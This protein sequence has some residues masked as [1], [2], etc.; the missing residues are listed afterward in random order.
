MTAE[1]VRC[2][3]SCFPVI[4][5]T[6]ASADHP[7]CS[8]AFCSPR[9][10][11]R[12]FALP[13]FSLPRRYR[14]TA[15]PALGRYHEFVGDQFLRRFLSLR[16][17]PDLFL[18]RADFAIRPDRYGCWSRTRL[19]RSGRN[20][21][22]KPAGGILLH[23]EP[24]ARPSSDAGNRSSSCLRLVA[25]HALRRSRRPALVFVG[26][27]DPT[28]CR[29]RCWLDWLLFGLRNRRTYSNHAP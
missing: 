7:F 4:V 27:R 8:G 3:W 21:V 1:V 9:F 5:L 25:R 19:A 17:L 11:R 2:P 23:S 24:L 22:G 12:G 16:H 29:S 26:V 14:S 28:F 10:R 6:S 13:W 20:P 18:A 15:R